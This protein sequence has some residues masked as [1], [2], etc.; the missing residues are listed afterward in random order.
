MSNVLVVI[1]ATGNQGRAVLTYFQQYE[2][3]YKLRGTSRN[4][5]SDAAIALAKSGIEIVKADLNDLDSLK[6]AFK[7]A[8][9]IFAYTAG[10]E[11]LQSSNLIPKVMS[12]ELKPPV[13]QYA[14]EIE[15]QQGKNVAD[16]AATIPTLH[17][18]VWSSLTDVRGRSGGKYVQAYHL[19]SKY[20]VWQYMRDLPAL[21]DK[22]SA[23]LMGGF[24]DNLA[25]T[26]QQWGISRQ[27]NGDFLVSLPLQKDCPIPW[28]DV[29]RDTGAF[30]HALTKASPGTHVLGVSEWLGTG[31][32]LEL[33]FDHLGVKGRFEDI[34]FEA[35][36]QNDPLG[37]KLQFAEGF[38]FAEE[39]GYTGGDP[40]VVSPDDVGV[41][42]PSHC[43][44][45]C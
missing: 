37:L 10:S 36:V 41:I 21:K 39:F 23:V 22:A 28:V 34:S 29:E 43:V 33:L 13:G 16:A 35:A 32:Y 6:H 2:P 26:P 38:R 12:G 30:V 40:E 25:N 45:V 4:P 5:S 14:Y 42:R 19:D 7:D 18:L 9:V 3:S 20:T 15:V 24:M 11:I 17:R 27:T 8:T 44:D 1:G 31:K